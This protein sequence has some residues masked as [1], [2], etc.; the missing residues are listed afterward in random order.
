M[1]LPVIL[2]AALLA[3]KQNGAESFTPSSK[4]NI[5]PRSLVVEP[6][7]FQKQH[8]R[9][10]YITPAL[11]AST[12]KAGEEDFLGESCTLTPEGYGFSSSAERILE[13]SKRGKGFYAAKA[14]ERVIDVMGGITEG[15]EDVALVYEG[16]ELLG[17]FTET[18]YIDV[19]LTV[20][21]AR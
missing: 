20:F 14:S 19:S 11:C 6:S 16:T 2:T 5:S 1:V 13:N 3:S 10:H 17:I 21:F 4:R 7:T 12:T 9:F 8:P 18:D 15:E